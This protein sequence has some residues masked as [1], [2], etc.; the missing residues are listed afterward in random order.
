MSFAMI[1]LVFGYD[2][3]CRSNPSVA[4]HRPGVMNFANGPL[5]TN[6]QRPRARFMASSPA[7]IKTRVR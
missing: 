7:A 2:L 4:S 5:D 1:G 3:Q 6:S